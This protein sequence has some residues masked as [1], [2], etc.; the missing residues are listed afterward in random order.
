MNV[1]GKKRNVIKG[2]TIVKAR[3]GISLVDRNGDTSD[4]NKILDNTIISSKTEGIFVT[5]KRVV[6]QGNT[7]NQSGSSGVFVISVIGSISEDVIIKGNSITNSKGAGI[8]IAP[9]SKNTV[10]ID[11]TLAGNTNGNIDEN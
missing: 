2:N 6:I 9:E 3:I 5:G 1:N 10:V 4:E 7:I 11:N 8:A